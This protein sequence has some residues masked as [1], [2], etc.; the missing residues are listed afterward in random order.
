MLLALVVAVLAVVGVAPAASAWTDDYPSPWRSAAQD[1]TSDSWGYKNRECTSFVAWRLHARNGF[2]MPRGIGNG[3]TWHSWFA[4]RGYAVNGTPAVGAIAESATHVAWV[5]A[6]NG[7]GTVTVEDYNYGYTGTYGE[8]RVAVSAFHYIHARDIGGAGFADGAFLGSIETGVVY[9]VVGGAP[10]RLYNQG[11]VPGFSGSVTTMVHQQVIDQMPA[12]PADG[13][14]V[15]IV[16]AGGSGIYR[17]VG[18]A[19]VRLFNWGALPGFDGSRAYGINFQSLVVLDHMRPVPADGAYINIVEAGGSGVYR[20]VGG[21][22]VRLFNWGALP[23]FDG[24]RVVDVNFQSLVNLD[25][26][27]PV[28]ADGAYISIVEAGGSGIYRFA[29]G[30]PVRLFNWGAL[31]G[32]DGGRVVDV[33]FDSLATLDHMRSVPAD[34]TWLGSAETGIVYRVAGGAALRLYNHGALPGFSGANV[35]MVNQAT[36]D[37]RDHLLATPV[38]G[39]VLQ[40]FP[41]GSTWTISAGH[42]AS[43]GPGAAA[44]GVDDQTAEEFPAG[45]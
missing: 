12:Y 22:P 7:D 19:P 5:E 26:M 37:N 6:V 45:S 1:S 29:G 10:I 42:R 14:Y 11:V 20:F 27:A 23:G 44:V 39:T 2:E 13:A 3:G 16:E 21:A 40:G 32:F 31:P 30:A 43:A 25:H 38:D 28:P 41:S 36:L 17:F 35:V 4:A 15:N 34:G 9:R 24:G 18:G 8:R 33:N